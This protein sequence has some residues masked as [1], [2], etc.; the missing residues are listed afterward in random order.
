M[1]KI[2]LIILILVQISAFSQQKLSLDDAIKIALVNNYSVLM[3]KLQ[4]D[5]ADN[6]VTTANAGMLPRFDLGGS[7]QYSFNSSN[8]ILSFGEPIIVTG[9]ITK[10]YAANATLNWTIFDGM[11]MFVRYDKLE[12]A[13]EKSD[14]ELQIAMEATIRNLVN[15]YYSAVRQ[16]ENI[17]ILKT[18]LDLTI[19]RFKRVSNQVEYGAASSIQ[20]LNVKVDMNADST[21]LLQSELQSNNDKLMI[22]FVLGNKYNEN[23]ELISE[24]TFRDIA[25]LEKLIEKAK[26]LNTS[27]NKALKDKELS[28]YDK[29]LVSAALFPRINLSGGYTYSKQDAEDG[30]F[31]INEQEGMNGAVS[32][33]WDLFN[34]SQSKRNLQNAQTMIEMMN[35]SQ[36]LIESQVEMN[37]RNAF[38]NY[39]SRMKILKMEE[40]NLSIAEENFARTKELFELGNVTSLE[41]RQAQINLLRNRQRIN[42]SKFMAKT[43][44]TEL[45]L[46]SGSI[47]NDN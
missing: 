22:N 41:L 3:T 39:Q 46:L 47:L 33:Q 14:I 21:E 23:Y 16:K 11:G 31:L 26:T 13:R 36:E 42:N 44:E 5:I 20:I 15:V 8:T 2:I 35:I 17:E 40:S 43:A 34:L 32:F 37:I 19:D 1:K 27:I 30:F 6:N 4:S 9:N 25:T 10:N 38:N 12:A 7:A 29:K 24:V 45:L 28:E 18:N